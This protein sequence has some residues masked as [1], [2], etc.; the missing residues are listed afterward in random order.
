MVATTRKVV[1]PRAL[2][3]TS[4]HADV[5]PRGMK[6]ES[7]WASGTFSISSCEQDGAK[8]EASWSSGAPNLALVCQ[9]LFLLLR[10]GRRLAMASARH[11]SAEEG[12]RQNRTSNSSIGG[13]RAPSDRS[14]T[15]R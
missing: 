13:R 12:A 5:V 14:A 2:R 3:I 15:W 11:K 6:P 1:A 10:S 9:R 8:P 7:R 4:S